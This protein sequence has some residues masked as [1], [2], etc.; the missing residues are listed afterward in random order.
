MSQNE[1]YHYGVLGM[2]WGRKKAGY[3]TYRQGMKKAKTAGDKAFKESMA[4]DRQTLKGFGSARKAVNNAN[5][6]KKQA[7]KDSIAKDKEFNKKQRKNR[8]ISNET[9]STIAKSSAV[10][11]G[12]LAVASILNNTEFNISVKY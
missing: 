10:M 6:A 4:R 9:I 12:S 2:K 5:A 11:V 3:V 1:L 7:M 8:N